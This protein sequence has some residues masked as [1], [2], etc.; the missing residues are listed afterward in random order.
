MQKQNKRY[1]KHIHFSNSPNFEK[2]FKVYSTSP[3]ESKYVLNEDIRMKLLNL[4]QKFNCSINLIFSRYNA[5]LMIDD[6]KSFLRYDLNKNINTKKLFKKVYSEI[7][8]ILEVI[9]LINTHLTK[10]NN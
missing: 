7:V 8:D 2:E 5:Y 1:G 3:E 10:H 4:K 9:N 6:N